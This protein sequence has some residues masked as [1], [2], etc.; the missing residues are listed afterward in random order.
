[1]AS[2]VYNIWKSRSGE[3]TDAQWGGSSTQFRA[4]LIQSS[5]YT[6]D[7]D[8]NFVSSGSGD[9]VLNECTG[10]GYT[11]GA[12]YQGAGRIILATRTVSVDD[13]NNRAVYDT[14]D[15]VFAAIDVSQSSADQVGLAIIAETGS[16]DASDIP[17][18]YFD[19][20][21]LSTA[22]G[23]L[24]TNGGDLTISWSTS[25]AFTLT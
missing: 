21:T 16:A 20:T 18:V 10:V 8:A 5:N 17:V 25:G 19:S 6:F 7:E 15:I 13:T 14:T 22:A 12:G 1:M 4:M 11:T 3:S 9:L 24:T 23:G 2:G